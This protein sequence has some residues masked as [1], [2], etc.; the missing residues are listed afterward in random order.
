MLIA[1]GNLT[2]AVINAINGTWIEIK[3]KKIYSFE[4]K[5]SNPLQ[6]VLSVDA[7]APSDCRISFNDEICYLEFNKTKYRLWYMDNTKDIRLE[8]HSDDEKIRLAKHNI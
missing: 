6:V 4:R 1:D 5:V 8:L 7:T 2:F 3:T